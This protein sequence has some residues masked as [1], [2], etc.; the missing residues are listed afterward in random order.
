MFLWCHFR[1]DLHDNYEPVWDKNG[2]Y[3][4][5][6]FAE[7]A[8]EIVRDHAV[9]HRDKVQP[10]IIIYLQKESFLNAI[11]PKTYIINKDDRNI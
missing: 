3:S 7:R 10:V 8:I 1:L 5:E 9:Y 11:Y 6:I 4:T 2:S